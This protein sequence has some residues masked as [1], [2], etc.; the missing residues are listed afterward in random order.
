MNLINEEITHNVF[1]EGSIVGHEDS[2]ITVDF[3][4]NLKKFVYPDAFENFI[5]LNDRSIAKSL[6]EFF[7]KRKAEEKVLEKERKK[8]KEYQMLEHQR[9][10]KLKNHKIHESSQIVFWMDEE[11][12]SDIFTDWQ[13]STGSIQS[14]KNKGQPNRVARLSANSASILTVRSSDQLETERL[15]HGIFMVDDTFSGNLGADGMVASDAEFRIRLTDQEAEQMPFWNYYVNKNYPERASWNSGKFRYFD[16]IW[17]A[18]ILQDIISIKKDEEQIKEAERF[19][20]HFCKMNALD[21]DNI[22][23]ADGILR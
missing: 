9:R 7:V 10:E 20:E 17:T 11:E 1:G 5:T 8:E 22:P 2:V 15:I 18:Q 19:L 14:G 13:V 6:E 21:I 3:N 4:K 12:Q 16:N 23:E